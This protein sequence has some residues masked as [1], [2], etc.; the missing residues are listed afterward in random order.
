MRK[1]L[2][3]TVMVFC[4][5]WWTLAGEI[6]DAAQ[7]GDLEQVKKLL[8]SD[9]A[10][11]EA[12]LQDGKK[13]LHKAAYEGHV[14]VVRFLLEKGA[15]VDSRSNSGSSPL[16]GAAFHNRP[17]IAR[18]LVEAGADV[19]LANNYGYTPL[20]SAA[21]GG[22]HEV[23][24]ILLDAGA[25]P[26]ARTALGANAI[27][28]AAAG[29]C[30]ETF[31]LL[32]N[33]GVDIKAVDNNAENLLHYAAAGGNI[34]I[35]EIAIGLGIDINAPDS[36]NSTPIFNAIEAGRAEALRFLTEQGAD[37]SVRDNNSLT[38]LHHAVLAGYRHGDSVA[39]ELSSHLVA[40]GADVNAVDRWDSTP[41]DRVIRTD[42]AD[43][44]GLL[45]PHVADINAQDP[46]GITPLH[47][48]IVSDKTEFV[49]H[50]LKAGARTDIKENNEGATALHAAVI[51]GNKDVVET[52]L[53]HV[54]DINVTDASGNS[55]LYYAD[56][57][58]HGQIAELLKS[59]GAAATDAEGGE[60]SPL[61][62]SRQL[63]ER[64]AVLWYLGH[65]GWAIKTQNHLLLFDYWE[66]ATPTEPC[67]ANGH[68]T[69]AELAG[70]N[71]EVFVSHEHRDHFDP[72][73]FSWADADLD[74]T[75]YFGVR[76]ENLNQENRQGYNG[77]EY[78][79]TAPRSET[80][81]DGMLIRTIQAN[82][83][84][85]GF[86][87][88]VDGITIYH[89]GDHAGWREGERDGFLAEVDY[90]DGIDAD[91]DFAFVNVTGCHAGDTLALAEA[92]FYTLEKLAPAIMVPTHGMDREHVY[93]SFADK[94][95]AQGFETPVLCPKIRGDHYVFR[96]D[97]IL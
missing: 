60:G 37:V 46:D 58:G 49:E 88:E 91:I 73:I 10:S 43:V 56:K 55:A 47:V 21:V 48:A 96:N 80:T 8:E 13:P 78:V 38:C 32:R 95:A 50:L 42:N 71:V 22:S 17:E 93:R 84:G 54:T 9:P 59:K 41:F 79:Y 75:Y 39:Y 82:D 45:L 20:L 85:V 36:Q 83:A 67:M 30:Q 86:L 63:G 23:V 94:V 11:I 24:Q 62:L 16:H 53:P 61:L 14:D 18:I 15:N 65:C 97:Q 29:G 7:Q 77:Q 74:L 1:S 92:T 27:L 89:A 44:F 68:I 31:D 6:H 51:K 52:L 28:S 66:N 57:Y 35:I 34:G 70:Q 12:P 72:A 90:L 3:L 64:E 4:A 2:I 25:D 33:S 19:N 87:I 76:P 81:S 40:A 69:P 5:A 26:N